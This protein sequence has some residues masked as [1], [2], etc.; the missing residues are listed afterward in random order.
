MKNDKHISELI[1]KSLRTRL[2]DNE[3]QEVEEYL[4]SNS[5]TRTFAKLSTAIHESVATMGVMAEKGESSIAMPEGAKS[6]L[7]DS[8]AS[9]LKDPSGF[10]VESVDESALRK[11][12]EF[13]PVETMADERMILGVEGPQSGE[14]KKFSSRLRLIRQLGEGGLGSVWLA[15]DEKLRRNVAVKQMNTASMEVPSNWQRF[16]R[17]AEIT[18]HLEH[19]N[20]VPLYQYG[21]DATTN[22]PFYAMRFVGK[23]TLADAIMEYHDRREAGEVRELELHRLLGSF[24]DVCQAIAYAHSR[25]VIHRDLKPENVALDNFGQVIVL[26]WGLAKLVED[27]DLINQLPEDS[28]LEDSA[29][30]KTMVGEVIGTPMFMAPE[31]AAGDLDSIDERTDIYGLGAILFSILTGLAPHESSTRMLPSESKSPTMQE[32][33]KWIIE[34]ESPR[35]RDFVPSVPRELEKICMKAMSKKS[36]ARFDSASDLADSVERWIAGQSEK[37]TRY[38]TM[39]MEGRELRADMEA[40]VRDLESNARFMLR[41]PP[42]QEL[43]QAENDEEVA[44]WR[45]RLAV[46][47]KGLLSAK[48]DYQNIAFCRV[49]GDKFTEIVRVG[50]VRSEHSTIRAIP[51]SRLRTAATPEHIQKIIMRNPEEVL[52]GLVCDP[53]CELSVCDQAM[54]VAGVPVYDEK[55]EEPYGVIMIDCDIERVFEKQMSRRLMAC[56]VVAAC[57][58]HQIMMHNKDRRMLEETR[59]QP[60]ALALPKFTSAVEAL[61]TQSEYIDETDQEV[62]GARL[63]LIPNVHG[64]MYLL[65]NS[66]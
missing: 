57:E 42:V 49:D 51:K 15:R 62:Y 27:S 50:R 34:S 6:R 46:I 17:E 40:T 58:T 7:K 31:Q 61:K 25:G 43:I 24:L 54:L 66:D 53:M 20:I 18:G 33:L 45:E 30:A 65:S 26:D 16:R 22:E 4:K 32:I 2:D 35:P 64:L 28:M 38:E 60:V 48:P 36:F 12:G 59:R 3:N 29:L 9:F 56:E 47:F 39:R 19:P 44:A 23:R 1:S 13:V 14:V 21:I 8:V 55:T 63:W 5:E 10:I 11:T 52:S 41:L 37:Q